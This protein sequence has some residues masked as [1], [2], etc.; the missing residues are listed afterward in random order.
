[1]ATSIQNATFLFHNYSLGERTDK[2]QSVV[3]NRY[4]NHALTVILPG[5]SVIPHP[6]LE[7]FSDQLAYRLHRLPLYRLIEIPFIQAFV[8]KGAVHMMSVNTKLDTS[9]CVA[10]TPSGCL[11]LHLTKD[12]YEQLGLEARK[13]TY[14]EKISDIYVVQ[15]NLLADHFR[16]GKKGYDRVLWCL[17]DRLDL[18]FNFLVAWE[19]HDD[20]VCSSSLGVYFAEKC[21]RVERVAQEKTSRVF[22]SLPCPKIDAVQPEGSED[23]CHYQEVFEW[24]GAVACGIDI[25]SEDTGPDS[26]TS[27]LA[28]PDPKY[29]CP[30]GCVFQVSGF[31]T[32]QTVLKVWKTL[33]EYTACHPRKLADQ[34]DCAWVCRQP[35]HSQ[36]GCTQFLCLWR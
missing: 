6:V 14:H 5:A 10:V 7:C 4:F 33:R 20:K 27:T 36:A 18:A 21:P 11:L 16:P 12:T 17:K 15:I 25:T 8:K 1:M 23:G 26:Y 32:P 34:P 24:L 13:Q 35:R 30:R 31:I 2:E 3:L 28:C 19:P 29:N 9:D 22:T